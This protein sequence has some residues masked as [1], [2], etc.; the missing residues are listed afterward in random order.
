MA[1]TS[2]HGPID[3]F[4]TEGG[5]VMAEWYESMTKKE[6]YKTWRFFEDSAKRHEAVLGMRGG[7]GR[8]NQNAQEV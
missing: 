4:T 1:K 6:L 3:G 7:Y 8:N 5:R 2:V